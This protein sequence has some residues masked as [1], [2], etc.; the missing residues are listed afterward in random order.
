MNNDLISR[1]SLISEIEK[2]ISDNIYNN[3]TITLIMNIVRKAPAAYDV[4]LVCKELERETGL[5]HY[6]EDASFD[7]KLI[8]DRAG[9]FYVRWYNKNF[10]QCM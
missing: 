2:S 5:I 9:D 6:T 3:S 4:D 10:R 7:G 1:K 8:E